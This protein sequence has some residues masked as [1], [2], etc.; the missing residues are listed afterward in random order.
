M[1]LLLILAVAMSGCAE[2]QRQALYVPDGPPG[3]PPALMAETGGAMPEEVPDGE[4]ARVAAES[5]PGL[6]SECSDGATRAWV[7]SSVRGS[8]TRPRSHQVMYFVRTYG[9][10]DLRTRGDE[11]VV[12]QGGREVWRTAGSEPVLAVDLDGDGKDEWVE[13]SGRCDPECG[14]ERWARGY[15]GGRAVELAHASPR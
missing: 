10:D 11:I 8:F 15:E 12:Y 14:A 3:P 6:G 9:C 1:K 4:A 13:E 5:F 2:H 7:K